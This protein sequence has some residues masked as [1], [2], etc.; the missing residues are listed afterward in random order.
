MRAMF[1]LSDKLKTIYAGE[2]WSI[3]KVTDSVGMFLDCTSLRGVIAYDPTKLDANYANYTTGYFVN[4]A[5]VGGYGNLYKKSDT[6]YHLIFNSTGAIAEGYTN[7]ELVA[8]GTNIV[9]GSGAIEVSEGVSQSTQPWGIYS[10]NIIKVKIEE[11]IKPTST[12][13]YFVGLT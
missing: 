8:R 10:D 7:S 13:C 6:E 5:N 9:N 1:Y 11:Q 4:K 3:N 2:K 12:A